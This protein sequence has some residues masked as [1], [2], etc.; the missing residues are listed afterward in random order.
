MT[1]SDIIPIRVVVLP[2][3]VLRSVLYE[4]TL[5]TIECIYTLYTHRVVIQLFQIMCKR[6]VYVRRHVNNSTN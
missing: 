2:V 3:I 6:N 4:H 1:L 5:Y